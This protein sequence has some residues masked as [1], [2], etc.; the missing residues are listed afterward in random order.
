[1][2]IY[3]VQGPDGRIYD[4]EG[5][6]GAAEAD[7]IAAVR[8]QL[9]VVET[10][11]P[12]TEEPTFG[13]QVKEFAK[14][15]IPGAIGMGQTALTGISALL[16]EDTEKS[17]RQYIDRGAAALKAPF[18][19]APGY[20]ETVGRKFGEAT[21]SILPFL[22]MGPLGAA[23]RAGMVGMGVGAGAGEARIRAEQENATPEQRSTATALGTIPGAFEAFA[24]MKILGRLSTPIQAGITNRVQRAL[25]AGGE[26]AAQEAASQ[27][28]QNLIAKGVYKPD[29]AIIEQVGESAAYGGATGA[30]V[31]GI[32]DMAIGRRAKSVTQPQGQPAEQKL[33][34]PVPAPEAAQIP[35]PT[36]RGEEPALETPEE[37]AAGPTKA[38][39]RKAAAEQN[40]Y[41]KQYERLQKEREEQA[42]EYERIKALTPE[43]YALEQMQGR[44]K[45]AKNK[46]DPAI[47]A[48]LDAQLAE[49]GYQTKP[50]ETPKP[51]VEYA[52]KQM[53]L[54]K[55]RELQ[56]NLNTYADYLLADPQ[57]AA[58]LVA[59]KTMIPGLPEAQSY[60]VL[61]LVSKRLQKTAQEQATK[62]QE[63]QTAAQDRARG[64]FAQQ[65]QDQT[66]DL[67]AGAREQ[68]GNAIVRPEIQA[69]Q[70]IG[71]R[72]NPLLTTNRDI[73]AKRAEEELIGKLVDT[74]PQTNGR[75]TPGDVYL[76]LGTKKQDV[77]DL[78][79][80]LAV[81]RLTGNKT[82]QADIKRQ[83]DEKRAIPTEGGLGTEGGKYAAE[84]I[85]RSKVPTLREGEAE[86]DK[87]AAEQRSTLLGMARLLNST[88]IMLPGKREAMLREAKEKYV[89]Q[90]AAEIEARR[91]A[92]DLPPMADWEIAEARARALEGL[93]TLTNNWGTFEDPVISVKALQNIT[94]ES[95]YQ[96]LYKA[97][98]R[99]ADTEKQDLTEKTGKSTQKYFYEDAE[100][101]RIEGKELEVPRQTGARVAAP[102]ELSL[103]NRPNI[104][105]TDAD[106]AQQFIEQVLSQI[107]TK[108]R[109][110][111]EPTIEK[112]PPKQVGDMASLAQLF[113]KAETGG[114]TAEIDAAT[115]A[116]LENLRNQLR[117][118]TD[119][120]FVSLARETAQKVA[121]GN[122][123]NAFDVRDLGEMM[124]AFEIAGRSET[125]PGATP[126]ELQ[127]TS[128]QP[129]KE[130]FPE[131]AVQIQRANPANFQ[132]MLDSKNIQGMR[133]ALA[134]QRADNIAALQ[135][136]GKALPT[137]KNRLAKAEEKYKRT[138]KRAQAAGTE[139]SAY[140]SEYK[141]ALQDAQDLVVVLR[142][143][144][145]LLENQLKDVEL[146]KEVLAK[147][148]TD[149]RF[150][151]S[152]PKMLATEK[153]L[154]NSIKLMESEIANAQNLIASIEA[155]YQAQQTLVAPA[156]KRAEKTGEELKKAQAELSAVKNEANAATKRAERLEEADKE[157]KAKAEAD[158]GT[159]KEV[160]E[161]AAQ[162]GREGLN[163]PGIRLEKDT[164]RMK[165]TIA[166]MRRAMGSLDEQIANEKDETKLAELKASRAEYERK[167]ETVYA[168]A[169]S[170][171]T[172]LQSKASEKAEKEYE[173]AQK[174]GFDQMMAKRRKRAGEKAPRLEKIEQVPVY[175]SAKT[176]RIVQPYRTARIAETASAITDRLIT[177]RSD[178]AEVNR[179]IDFLRAN[180]KDK[181]KNRLTDT[182]KKLQ[183][184]QTKLKERIESLDTRQKRIISLESKAEYE[185]PRAKELRE[186][187]EVQAEND[188]FKMREA[189]EEFNA[190]S[191]TFVKK[192]IAEAVRDG[193]IL[194]ALDG[195]AETGSTEFVRNLAERLRPL[196]MRTKLRTEPGFMVGGKQATGVYMPKTNEIVIDDNYITQENLMHEFVHAATDRV[197]NT[198]DADLTPSQRKAKAELNALFDQVKNDPALVKEYGLTDIDEFASEAMS[199]EVFQ[200]KLEQI[201]TEGKSGWE[202][203]KEA[204]MRFFG[205]D[206]RSNAFKD[207]QKSID[208]IFTPSRKATGTAKPALFRQEAKAAGFEN[209]LATASNL[210]AAP[211]TVRENIEANLGLAFRTQV[212]DRLAPLEKVAN[213][214]M[215]AFKGMQMMYYLRMADQKM[216]FV[217]QS[218]GRGV[219][220][221][222]EK[223]RSDGKVERLLESQNGPNLVNVVNTL[224]DA[225]GMN[226][227]AANQLFTLYLAAKRADRVGY[228]VL[229]F[230]ASEA[231]IKSAVAK[232]EANTELRDVFEK[233]RDQYNDYNRD[234][235]KFLEDTGAITPE[236][237]AR[238][239]K[240]NDYIPYYR[241]QNG[242]AVL[243]IGGE[244][245]FKV[246]N[247][248]DQPQLRQLIGGNEKIMDF[249][250]SSVQNTSM[251]MDMGLRNQ[252]AKNAMFELANLDMAQFLGGTPS[253]P[254]IVRFKDKGVE[255]FVRIDTASAGIPADLLVKGMEGI[256]VNNTA[257]VKVMGG[258]AT[259]LRRSITVSPLYS[260]RQVF[261]DS[262]AAP[263]LS[264]ANFTPVVGALKQIGNSATREKLEAR[265]IVGG[266][267]L[268]GTNE[269]LT[270]ILGELQSGKMGVG[271][272]IAKA[273]AIA[274]EAD[275]LTRRAQYDSYI[276]QG[277]SEMEATLMSL[278]SM[279]FNRKGL[280]PSARFAT[281]VIPFFNAQLQSLDVLYRSMTGKMPMSERLDIQ[282]KLLRRGGLLASTA[283]AYA[284]MM[285]DDETYKNANPDEKYNNFFVHVPGIKEAIRVPIPFEIGYIFKS[286][287]EAIVNTMNSEKGGEEAYK[288]F[289]NI[290]IQTVPGG[291]SLFLPAAIKPIVEGVTNY[292]FFTGRSLETKREQM[293][294]AQYRYRDNTSEL[295]KQVGAMTGTSPIKIEN[296]IRGYTGGMGV[297]LA[298]SF[299]FA[300]P[301]NGTP[302]QAAKRLSDAAVIGP[303]F[304]PADA[305]GIVG[306]VYDRVTTLTETK[307]TYD[308]LLKSGQR[309]EAMEFLQRNMDDYAKSAI[310]GNVQQ[311]L[312]KVTQA[313][314]AVKASSMSPDEKRESLDRL[315]QLRINL[316]A[317]V[318]GAL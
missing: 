51:D 77:R 88:Q 103:K 136:A 267:I 208:Q 137:L 1:M 239:A 139:A 229:N 209:E 270:R 175:R 240:T 65:G 283:V 84:F 215:D 195:I 158:I 150:L 218:V 186:A 180:G 102:D 118:N 4:V 61:N 29:Q 149:M 168:D 286:L 92:F 247:L 211:K 221:L 121:E 78:Q 48:E 226:A 262:V 39:Q 129:Q 120:E 101:N 291:T 274:M 124:K 75:V 15:V 106:A 164:T 281:T 66:S 312:G 241:E 277:L 300:M 309:A 173:D 86:G 128:A 255:K 183:E 296:L 256:P 105:A 109:T 13:G 153:P 99:R 36:V 282:G 38:A 25:I 231:N 198:P 243:V 72:P 182:F 9:A 132:K 41:L 263:L 10:P 318:R 276:E 297:A 302:E 214:Q 163:L 246:G 59:N 251:I 116:L 298:Q 250:T 125:R 145:V 108:G 141:T 192:D 20:E 62:T 242:N 160:F 100:G 89:A 35:E 177:A 14:G 257:I 167:L 162:A 308:N 235:V 310:A 258:F 233:A 157:A 119:P 265:G 154:R 90:H 204:V 56:P 200:K 112:Q 194:D 181:V 216:S 254:D 260:A 278:E 12:K 307:R 315:Q 253:G 115:I 245:T 3:S 292:S 268:T 147:E 206:I 43:E 248:T 273:E 197:L 23:G 144:L 83:L 301:T 18:A 155:S 54:V 6:E 238:L 225:P 5:P 142:D 289:K 47:Q 224:K 275:A 146:T 71:E 140:V 93:N 244:G 123:P 148:P 73:E 91:K 202:R 174:A 53:A 95:V 210:I 63:R 252:A 279:N 305:G 26:E 82:L 171:K 170:V 232:I 143:E 228:D 176:T 293:E 207:A 219:P 19:A 280:S 122:L 58:Q 11:K 134:K 96:N 165:Q 236:E 264:G 80:Q 81:A 67:L 46:Y 161:A 68:V 193:R 179:R 190:P 261:R 217:Q 70:R 55:D 22:A 237:A 52:A 79:A 42:A 169:P 306:A 166:N 203:F 27:I 45:T 74:L 196:L 285:Q 227:Q 28:A 222:V 131:A 97:T 37:I 85:S 114:R 7:V 138:Q 189:S 288:A 266:Q 34:T 152:A 230:G 111:V 311:Q 44:G 187:R 2:A 172:V 49:L 205:V 213:E 17:A 21:G 64:L 33:Q 107:E 304:Q 40:A 135:A 24:P 271:Q 294:Q 284:L 290:A 113:K 133:D 94:R 191:L 199:N 316:A 98:Q 127:R 130:L 30:L 295:A 223:Q 299:D 259:L 76:G 317:S 69:L 50:A 249:L 104:A 57:A 234:L 212:L 178:L 151:I 272:F 269:D 32:L 156:Q 201:K 110:R 188:Q 87:F 313:I 184:E 287:P 16:P 8:R 185:T 303:L 117:T 314:N 31:Q 220:Q 159:P 126:E 60:A